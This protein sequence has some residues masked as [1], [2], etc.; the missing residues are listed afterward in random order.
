MRGNTYSRTSS[1]DTILGIIPDRR[2]QRNQV[3]KTHLRWSVS[4]TFLSL[5]D[6]NE[7]LAAHVRIL[8][9]VLTPLFLTD[10]EEA[11]V[12]AFPRI[13]RHLRRLT[14]LTLY[15]P[16]FHYN[17]E[18]MPPEIK[19]AIAET[20]SGPY[21]DSLDFSDFSN[22]PVHLLTSSATLKEVTIANVS[23]P[24]E[25]GETPTASKDGPT[26]QMIP[27]GQSSPRLTHLASLC[28]S[29]VIQHW[30]LVDPKPFSTLE[31]IRWVVRRQSDWDVF[32][33]VAELCKETLQKL[34]L[35]LTSI[36]DAVIDLGATSPLP[37]VKDL[38]LF[39]HPPAEFG[40]HHIRCSGNDII[41]TRDVLRRSQGGLDFLS[42]N[43]T[44]QSST[45]AFDD[46]TGILQDLDVWKSLDEYLSNSKTDAA[47]PLLAK[48][49]V[50]IIY[51]IT[52]TTRA[53]PE[54]QDQKVKD[55]LS[56]ELTDALAL[57][58]EAKKVSIDVVLTKHNLHHTHGPSDES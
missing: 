49:T 46:S 9:V 41:L 1:L 24:G 23:I 52:C 25:H 7:A 37:R 45:L 50:S 53:E 2:A 12:R 57:S 21:I 14:S 33:R 10:L 19:E 30:L 5:L 43:I 11:F 6:E 36:E 39:A 18:V 13:L 27:I 47:T 55:R 26:L 58:V 35:H 38:A 22:F 48:L 34:S 31:S 42:M 44:I 29:S 32:Q 17:W 28:A 20:C 54:G 56:K 16:W 3:M 51:Y 4:R 40:R 15:G 8:A